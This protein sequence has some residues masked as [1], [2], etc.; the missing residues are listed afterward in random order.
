MALSTLLLRRLGRPVVGLWSGGASA[1]QGCE[2][3]DSVGFD[4]AVKVVVAAFC[5]G[6]EGP[7]DQEIVSRGLV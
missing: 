4:A 7:S 6:A 5:A 3:I 2:V 1:S